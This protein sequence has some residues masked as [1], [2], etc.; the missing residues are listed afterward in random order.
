[1]V[2]MQVAELAVVVR[3]AG[4]GKDAHGKETYIL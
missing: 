1:M 4:G 2:T 3:L